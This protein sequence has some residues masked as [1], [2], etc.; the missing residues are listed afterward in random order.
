MA[1][2]SLEGRT[3]CPFLLKLF[4]RTGAFHRLDEFSTP[5]LLPFVPVY[6]FPT[7]S[8][9]ELACHLAG[10]EQAVLP[11]PAVGTRIAFRLVYVDTRGAAES[12]TEGGGPGGLR[13]GPI[14]FA[15]RDLGSVV[16]GG[17]GYVAL[18]S[19]NSDDGRK[20]LADA[21]FVVGDYISC[22]ILPPLPDGSAA[23]ASTARSGRGSG[24]GE[25]RTTMMPPGGGG[26][27][28][29]EFRRWKRGGGA[30]S[31]P[32][33]GPGGGPG[34]WTDPRVPAGDWRRGER[35]PDGPW[36]RGGRGRG[37]RW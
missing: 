1:A 12:G 36:S 35:V 24:A 10:G 5:Q 28:R 4:Y 29:D 2:T 13:P 22:A 11:A 18:A 30:G 25:G 7:Y 32:N 8:L 23:P 21:R 16:I 33:G 26:D 37:G 15:V 19:P 6:A 17:E 9:D 14:R 20:T 3:T 31:G 34:L 27:R